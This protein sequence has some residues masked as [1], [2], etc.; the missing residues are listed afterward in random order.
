MSSA[1]TLTVG[2]PLM[3]DHKQTWWKLCPPCYRHLY[4]KYVVPNVKVER[5]EEKML[6]LKELDVKLNLE[7][8][9]KFFL[10]R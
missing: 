7:D 1:D 9:S 5:T 3:G 2:E 8:H 4:K 10:L 6:Q